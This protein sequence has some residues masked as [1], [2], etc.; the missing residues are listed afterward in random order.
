VPRTRIA[1]EGSSLYFYEYDDNLF[2]LHT[3]MLAHRL[4]R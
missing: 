4:E 1:C 3:S 2:E